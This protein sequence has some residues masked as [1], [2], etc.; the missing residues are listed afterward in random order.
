MIVGKDIHP[1]RELYY[2]GALVLEI[3][4]IT[5]DER[6]EYFS[7]YQELKEREK[8]TLNMFSLTLDWLFILGAIDGAKGYIKRCF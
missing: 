5:P 3:L 4:A 1:Q 2:L 6:I 7:L 8:T